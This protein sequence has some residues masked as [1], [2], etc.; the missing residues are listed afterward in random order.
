MHDYF[1]CQLIGHG[2]A[3][4]L[5]LHMNILMRHQDV[6]N[7][8]RFVRCAVTVL[9]RQRAVLSSE[10]CRHLWESINVAHILALVLQLA[11]SST[12]SH[13]IPPAT[14][15]FFKLT[16]LFAVFGISLVAANPLELVERDCLVICC[17]LKRDIIDAPTQGLVARCGGCTNPPQC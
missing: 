1:T 7:I 5:H 16:A 4:P 15:Q 17:A 6:V 10:A 12:I 13:L 14:M 9:I 8:V 3:V 11:S 2:T